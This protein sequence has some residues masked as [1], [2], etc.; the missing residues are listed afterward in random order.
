MHKY[1]LLQPEMVSLI[2]S[3]IHN[4]NN[5]ELITDTIHNIVHDNGQFDQYIGATAVAAVDLASNELQITQTDMFTKL[6]LLNLDTLRLHD[7]PQI[8]AIKLLLPRELTRHTPSER[9]SIL[10][11]VA[12]SIL[13]SPSLSGSFTNIFNAAT[14]IM[15]SRLDPDIEK[16]T[17]INHG[18]I[19]TSNGLA[20]CIDVV[21]T[22]MKRYKEPLATVFSDRV[23][24]LFNERLHT[25]D[26][27]E[28]DVI[29]NN[30]K[31]YPYSCAMMLQMYYDFLLEQIENW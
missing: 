19:A 23:V 13:V 31:A 7:L 25:C 2:Q 28:R 10:I 27:V 3:Y 11:A 30:L 24:L 16:P 4:F 9:G 17:A 18:T 12:N 8:D 5:Q 26:Q 15:L 20:A 22:Y 21:M 14:S 29:Y 1:H 6:G